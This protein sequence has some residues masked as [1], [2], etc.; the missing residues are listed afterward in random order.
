MSRRRYVYREVAPGQVESFEVGQDW[1]ATGRGEG[2]KSEEEVYGHIQA[3]DG[4]DLSTRRRH[5]EYMAAKGITLA[6]DYR[7]A[8]TKASQE[9]ADYYTR[10]PDKRAVRESLERAVYQ[11]TQKRRK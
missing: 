2:H 3:T 8:W 5:R 9:R 11:V 6:E 1:R 7:D 10:G 4:T